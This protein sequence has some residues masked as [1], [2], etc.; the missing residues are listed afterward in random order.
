MEWFFNSQQGV[1]G[2]DGKKK[3]DPKVS[4]QVL[5]TLYQSNNFHN[6]RQCM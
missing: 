5:E 2:I 4:F 1:L 6:S 3:V